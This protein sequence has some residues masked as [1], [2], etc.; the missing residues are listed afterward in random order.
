MD[1]R[2]VQLLF[3]DPAYSGMVTGPS[4]HPLLSTSIREI[5]EH[6]NNRVKISN[7]FIGVFRRK[8]TTFCNLWWVPPGGS[9][10]QF[11]AN[12]ERMLPDLGPDMMSQGSRVAS[13]AVQTIARIVGQYSHYSHSSRVQKAV[14]TI[15]LYAALEFLVAEL[16]DSSIEILL[17]ELTVDPHQDPDEDEDDDRPKLLARHFEQALLSRPSYAYFTTI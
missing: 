16:I 13:K 12:L 15:M 4:K 2:F 6:L 7:E 11:R 14:Q 5:A 9:F 1:E 10:D 8:L 3:N 17:Q